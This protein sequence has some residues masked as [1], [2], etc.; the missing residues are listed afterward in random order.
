MIKTPLFFFLSTALIF[1]GGITGCTNSRIVQPLNQGQ[2]Q[3]AF[4]TGGPII[5]GDKSTQPLALSSTSVAYGFSQRTTAFIGVGISSA[6]HDVYHLDTGVTHELITPYDYQPGITL[7]PQLNVFR[8][9]NGLDTKFYPQIDINAYWLSAFRDDFFYFG[10]S[11]WFELATKRAHQQ[12]QKDHWIP[13]IHGGYTFQGNRYGLAL[14]LKYIAPTKNNQ[15]Q[16]IDYIGIENQ[17][18][19]GTYL[20]I[21]RKFK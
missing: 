17:G 21:S 15:N 3:A 11:N 18:V 9:K 5:D 10:I 2:W 8:D 12:K 13:S 4:S 14:E 20:S 7:T 1:A 16:L 19:L 6:I